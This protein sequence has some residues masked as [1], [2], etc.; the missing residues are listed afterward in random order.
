MLPSL[1]KNNSYN[2]FPQGPTL[3]Q[4]ATQD[5]A[6]A[7]SSFSLP[8]SSSSSSKGPN[9][10]DE[11]YEM[12]LASILLYGI[13][14]LRTLSR[15]RLVEEPRLLALPISSQE[16]VELVLQNKSKIEQHIGEEWAQLYLDA[17]DSLSPDENNTAEGENN[18]TEAS[19][20]STEAALFDVVDIDDEYSEE[21]LVYGICVDTARRRIIVIFR[22]CTTRNDWKVS[23]ESF[24]TECPNPVVVINSTNDI[25]PQQ[26]HYHRQPKTIAI[27]SGFY[28]YL[29]DDRYSSDQN[30]HKNK[31][32]T[33]IDKL[34]NLLL[35]SYPG[36]SIYV[37]GHSLGG[38][39]ATVFAF[40]AAAASCQYN[41]LN[42]GPITCFPIASPM[43]GNLAFETAFKELEYQGQLR[44]LR[45]TNHFDIFT[46]LPDRTPFM[47]FF[48][49]WFGFFYYLTGSCLWFL[50][51]Q[52]RVYR[53]VGMDL[54]LY[55][56]EKPRNYKIKHSQGSSNY[57]VWRVF[58]DWKTHMKQTLQRLMVIPFLCFF[59]DCCGWKENFNVNHGI[60]EH[61]IRLK[62]LKPELQ[63]AYLNELYQKN[64]F[65]RKNNHSKSM[66]EPSYDCQELDYVSVCSG[67]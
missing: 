28:R 65:S 14:D 3:S 36:Y 39:L 63:G 48:A 5:Q 54:H 43:V 11:S 9:L 6:P 67:G 47:Y 21:E 60:Q 13:A 40:E 49:Y 12:I 24:L 22:G 15:D 64:R 20:K 50:C 58:Q 62:S 17:F 26:R 44:C 41:I 30:R 55:S 32:Q 56:P 51:C 10:Y 57:Y 38:A 46:Q 33:I 8:V 19:E 59:C 37:T 42:L 7:S 45:I 52:H 66:P 61:M 27:H 23:A 4:P 35:D 31:F 18:A 34:H 2:N 53:H 1:S 29:F 25:T 16:I